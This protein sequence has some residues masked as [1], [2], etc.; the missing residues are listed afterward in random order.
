MKNTLWVLIIL[1]IILIIFIFLFPNLWT[2]LPVLIVGIVIIQGIDDSIKNRPPQIGVLTRLNKKIW[3]PDNKPVILREGYNWIFLKRLLFDILIFS[4]DRRIKDLDPQDVLTPDNINIKIPISLEWNIVEEDIRTFIEIGEDSK[5][6]KHISD[7]LEGGLREYSR[8]IT[9]GPMEWKEMISSGLKTLDFLA[10]SLCSSEDNPPSDGYDH[11]EKINDHIPT[12]IL[13]DWYLNKNPQN[14][15]IREEWG[16]GKDFKDDW[17]DQFNLNWEKLLSTINRLNIDI[18]ILRDKIKKRKILLEKI[19]NGNA[20]IK[21]ANTGTY[22]KRL[23]VGD[24]KPFG[25]IYLADIALQKEE[26]ERNSE[27]YEVETDIKKVDLLRSALEKSGVPN[28][29]YIDCYNAIMK[30]KN[31]KPGTGFIYEG[32]LGNIAG[33]GDL[34]SNIMKGGKS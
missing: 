31:F 32:S 27:T 4:V 33:I 17:S 25:D 21:I 14:A 7:I 11:F 15:I 10:K 28:V 13:L 30:W 1:M 12:P 18:D 26:K 23:T 8:S 5:V 24:V 19:K 3:K 34:I 22:L 6:D 29:P 9:E 16:D 20:R 2:G